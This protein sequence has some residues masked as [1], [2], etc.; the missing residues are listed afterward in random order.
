MSAKVMFRVTWLKTNERNVLYLHPPHSGA[1][2]NSTLKLLWLYVL[3]TNVI[4][5]K[6]PLDVKS[7]NWNTTIVTWPK[8]RVRPKQWLNLDCWESHALT[9]LAVCAGHAPASRALSPLFLWYTPLLNN[10]LISQWLPCIIYTTKGDNADA[11]RSDQWAVL[12]R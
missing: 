4:T 7:C 2:Q 12:P 11:K 8:Q 10:S 6:L 9:L 3:H 1:S 5:C